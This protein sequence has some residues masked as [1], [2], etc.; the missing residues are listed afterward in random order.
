MPMLCKALSCKKEATYNLTGMPA[1][2]CKEH[3][4]PSM[5]NVRNKMC[6]Q[7][8]CTKRASFGEDEL[9]YCKKHSQVDDRNLTIDNK[10]CFCG[11]L[12][13]WSWPTHGER[14]CKEHKF[15]GM[16]LLYKKCTCKKVPTHGYA[17]L[18]AVCCVDCTYPDMVLIA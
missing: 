15:D 17:G 16:C 1:R 8:G 3:M 9:L 11:K 5:V 12:G 10:K 18:R 14:F 4:T 7:H 2:Y 13:N 6:T